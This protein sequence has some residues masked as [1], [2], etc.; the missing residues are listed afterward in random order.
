MLHVTVPLFHH[1]ISNLTVVP[2]CNQ[3]FLQF[4]QNYQDWNYGQEAAILVLKSG[5]KESQR[6]R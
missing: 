3:S 2:I 1:K 5:L 6:N 4:S